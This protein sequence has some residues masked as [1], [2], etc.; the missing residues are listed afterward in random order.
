[1]VAFAGIVLFPILYLLPSL[2]LA[3]REKPCAGVFFIINLLLGWT[4]LPWLYLMALALWPNS[5]D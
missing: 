2:L 5:K 3:W 1:M 4:V